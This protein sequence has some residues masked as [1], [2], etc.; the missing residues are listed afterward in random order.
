MN[1]ITS[2]GRI[3]I[4]FA[5]VLVFAMPLCPPLLALDDHNPIGA[6]G[7]FEGV[8]TTGCAY[9]VL[10]HNATRQIDDV[11]VP[12]AIGKY[13]LKMTRYY[14]SR[15]EPVYGL[16]G[17]GWTH[18]YQWSTSTYDEKISYPN[19][20]V[21]DTTCTGDWGLLGPLA[22]SDGWD[23][24]P[25]YGNGNFRLADGGTV[26]FQNHRLSS[27]I[28]PYG[29]T[30]TL[31]YDVNSG[32]L[33]K[34]TEA[35]GRYL[36]F[37]YSV[38]NGQ[39]M[40]TEVDAYDGRGNR[41]D[42]VVYHYTSKS[43]GGTIVTTAMCLTSVDYSDSQH[44]SYTYTTDNA[45]EH[46]GPPCPCS[47]KTLPLVSGCDD[48]HYAGPM[49]RIAYAYQ[50]QGPHG[51]ILNEKYWDGV[52]GHEANGPTVSSINPPLTSPLDSAPNFITSFT[53]TR[54]DGPTRT[55]NY[56]S[57]HLSR[58]PEE[59]CPTWN[60]TL[61]PAPQQF[62]QSYTDFQGHTTYVGY[63]A[64]WYVN[65]VQDA[66]GH[67]TTYTRG[68]PPYPA[69]GPKGIGQIMQIMH[70]GD[71]TH[72]DYTY[73]P[74][75]GVIGG[76]YVATVSDERQ[77]VTTYTRD[78]TTH[79]VT[80]IDYPSDVNTPASYEEFTYNSFGQVLTHHLRN[81]AWESFVYDSRGL[82]TD[83]YN[84][85]QSGV[86][87]GADP[88]IHYDYYTSA[89]GKLG[90]V[91][92]VKKMTL[93]A[94]DIGYFASETYEYD[95]TLDA[96]GITNLTGAAVGGR[97]LVTKITHGDYTY[98]QFKYDAY[99][100]KRWE[101]NELRQASSYTYDDY[102]RLLTAKNPLNKTT[103]YTYTP[104]SGGGGSSYKHTTSNPDTVTAPTGIVT[105]N[106]YD[107]NFR[108]T[109]TTGA[110]GTALAA[111]T[112]L[113][114]DAVGNQDY[115][116]DPRGTSS[117]GNY[118]TYTDY[119]SRNRKWQVR[120]PLGH[121]TQFYYDD[122]INITRIVRPD[123][124]TETKT[125]DAMNRVLSDTVPK[126]SNPV[127]N[128]TTSFTYNPS[129]TIQ[130][131]T[132]PNVHYTWFYYD[133]SDRK[134]QMTYHDSSSQY[135]AYD[136]AGNLQSRTT[137]NGETQWFYY[138]IRNFKYAHWWSDWDDSVRTPDWCYF[139][140]DATGRLTEAEN[141]TNGWG[142]NIISDVHR[143]YDAA[144]H[145]TQEQQIFSG[146]YPVYVN[147]PSYDDDGRLIRMY[148][149]GVTGYD[150]TYS[151]DAMGRFEK[152]FLTGT[153]SNTLLFQYRYDAASNETERDNLYNGVNQFYPRD[154]LNRMQYVDAKKGITVLAHEG[155]SY[156]LM[157]R[158]T[159]VSY[160]SPQ[161]ADSFQYYLDGELNIATLGNLGHTLT[162]N[163]DKMGNRTSV[164]D[165]N[166]TS[167]YVP[168]VINQY[169]PTAAGSS[170]TNGLEHEISSYSGVAYT[171]INDE[172]L[173][174][175]AAGTTY[176]MVYDALGRCITRSLSGGPTTY[177][178]YDG[179]K[180][181]L[182]DDASG[183]S[184]GVN[185]YGKGIDE[186]LERVAVGS[187]GN[188]YGY[189]PQ[190]NHEG[191]VTLLTD[192][193]GNVIE[194]YRYDAFGA[195]TIYTSTWATRSATIY[196]NRFLFTGREYAAT[197]RSTYTTPAFNFY[198]YRARAYNPQLG[199]F[200]SEDPKLFNAG[201]Y[202]LFRYCHND[203]IDFTDPM[204]LQDTALPPGPSHATP[205]IIAGQ[206]VDITIA[207]RIS[208]WQKSMESS[209]GGEQAF[210]V[211][212]SLQIPLTYRG[213]GSLSNVQKRTDMAN[214]AA[215]RDG[216]H[217]YDRAA[218]KDDFAPGTYKCNKFD[219][220]VERTARVTPMMVR[221]SDTGQMRPATAGERATQQVQDWRRLQRNEA[222]LPG[223]E[224][225][226][227][228]RTINASGHT[229]VVVS[230]GHGG[231]TIMSAHAV[232]VSPNSMQ[233]D[234]VPSTVYL[235]YTGE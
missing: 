10:N 87:S 48:T 73:Q 79:R 215:A 228:K 32:R 57:L 90:W 183:A 94:N 164:V 203:P 225:A 126:T 58:H 165:N 195:P 234:A 76:H 25:S 220:D 16:M 190:Q 204:G 18:G 125:Y 184:A 64:N 226:F 142:A 115:V 7:A 198:E 86:P 159:S 188:W 146:L 95:R 169:Y 47:I 6:T 123:T 83:K 172:R 27:I 181:I 103:T 179:D 70:T 206:R 156:D 19:G 117:P 20:S 89:D 152:I 233:F 41:I 52:A 49:R 124:T 59:T 200:M 111:T 135:W 24:H 132:D 15:S 167:T 91:D 106:V 96:S 137:V 199:R 88:H 138:D 210:H 69:S 180:P 107:A 229:G 213:E 130:K 105:S 5:I 98:Q 216:S 140:Y 12:G 11:V 9:N 151:Y 227:A 153:P 93:P 136:G 61:D 34:V 42:Y 46:P 207:E 84:P 22:I 144:G 162:Y 53:E 158:I 50:D 120:E 205:E 30:T 8:I 222:R 104:T 80:R 92:R 139:D 112:W 2:A 155:Y 119:D 197:Y 121:T 63:D 160:Q 62:L 39:T 31:T 212:M 235:R 75:T 35:G 67:T 122:G 163:L 99:G 186:L 72:I 214:I 85:K 44:A 78:A 173:K 231:T 118:T 171:Y 193:S 116:T 100:N 187:D 161:P 189:Y 230:D 102:S 177:Y 110:Y 81:G 211:E 28:D 21:Q 4:S 208:L 51:A 108:K 232:G 13:G 148:V 218:R 129:G 26:V 170:I 109:S 43:T 77:K 127:V 202:N 133:A 68:P 221:D 17:A 14:N 149:S 134:T 74:E 131:V 128:L 147:Y 178:I 40:L 166:V 150:F 201:D 196:D 219:Y 82:L 192:T 182:E 101:D 33:S 65:S 157:N 224:A 154:A 37:N 174:S 60:P 185:L 191:S 168:N 223:D 1:S 54:G 38:V 113:H 145:L 141:G 209:I 175:A 29:Q 23:S 97:G 176:S 45:P 71:G 56:T 55:F 36:Q 217:E 66:N 114:Y 143:Y 3:A 194:R